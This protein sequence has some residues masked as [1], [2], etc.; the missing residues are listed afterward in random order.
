MHAT[1]FLLILAAAAVC[2]TATE[3][4][5]CPFKENKP[6]DI[7]NQ[8]APSGSCDGNSK[9][10]SS[11]KPSIAQK[12]KNYLKPLLDFLPAMIANII[13]YAIDILAKIREVALLYTTFLTPS[14][15][16]SKLFDQYVNELVG[17]GPSC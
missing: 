12:F 11:N 5:S 3:Q 1:V 6:K 15:P 4:G 2:C 13:S 14:K 9:P 8:E 17:K 10:A 7:K 16:V